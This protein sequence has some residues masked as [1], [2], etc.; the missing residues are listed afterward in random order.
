MTLML[1]LWQQD[2]L[3]AFDIAGVKMRTEPDY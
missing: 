2:N 3:H 1:Y